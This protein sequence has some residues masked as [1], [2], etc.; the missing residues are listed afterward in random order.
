MTQ[1]SRLLQLS[2]DVEVEL[3]L[4]GDTL[5]GLGA[6]RVGGTR[7][8]AATV[9]LRP[10]FAT[11]DAIHY[12]DFTLEA[13]VPTAAGIELRTV[14]RG[15]PELY[16]EMMDEYSYNLA[17]SAVRAPRRDRL[18]W[19]LT[20][21][22]LDL[23]GQRFTGF[24]LA[25]RFT[26]A[27]A[28]IHR[29][30]TQATWEIGGR[31]TGNTLYHQS[32]TC[33][34]VYR[35][36]PAT[37]FST[38]C[39]KRLDLWHSWLGHSYQMLPRWGCIQ[40]FDFQAAPEGVLLG[41]W[42]G[43]HAVKSLLQKNPGEEVIFVLDEYD[44]PL[45][46]SVTTPAKHVLFSA[47]RR[48]PHQVVDLW[49]RAYDY[50]TGLIRDLFGLR[51]CVP[52]LGGGPVYRGRNSVAREQ[53]A[54]GPQPDWLWR[55]EG[56]KFYYLLEGDQIERHDFLYWLADKKLPQ[57][58]ARGLQ[59]V[60]FEPVH[61]SDFTEDAFAYHAETGWHGDLTVCSICGSRRYVP[62]A[63]YD[64]WR[65]WNYL[66]GKARQLGISLGHWVGLHLTPRAPILREHPEY[67]LQ[68]VNTLGHSGGYSH[69][70]ICS[71]NWA[72]GARQWFL[73]DLRRWHDEGGLEWLFFDSWPNLG[74]A[75]L[76]YGGG[77]EP[78]QW[79]LGGVLADLQRMG[80][81]W[82][83]FEG[84]SPFGVHQY[85]L[86]DPMQD[87]RGHVSGGVMGQNDFAWWIGHEYMGYNQMLGP[88]INPRRDRATLP[89]MSFRYAANRSLTLVQEDH[90]NRYPYVPG[91]DQTYAFLLPLMER[92]QMLPDDAGVHWIGPGGEALF[93]YRELAWPLPA[94]TRVERI[95]AGRPEPLSCPDGTLR[96][97]PLTAYRLLPR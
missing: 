83:S 76:N 52:Q 43:A 89:A 12:Q 31:A 44:F 65:G 33:P 90:G 21:Q 70:S 19:L 95:V 61:E 23:D 62:A 1:T 51:T 88:G 48:A 56:G 64:G 91:L 66:A 68:H 35:A 11:P 5:L 87:Y 46:G 71:I 10:D 86:W 63:C 24:S 37:H 77:M 3:L 97:A 54:D 22:T 41:Y 74:C 27:G 30:T 15:R 55:Q 28:E 85:G 59:R 50:T 34:P 47:G 2:P 67:V 73:D 58:H 84:T 93:A 57:L 29:L 16:G 7:L 8:R 82:F 13:V 32:Y 9:P 40:P 96:T 20:P 60:W 4:E 14:A 38:T 92:R 39:L 17:F 26:A 78:M 25:F 6:V 81:T 45:T 18:D 94:G 49:T 80:Y 72:S 36:E 53:L 75:P 69:L 42:P 79:E